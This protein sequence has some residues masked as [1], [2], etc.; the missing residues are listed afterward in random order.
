MRRPSSPNVISLQALFVALGG[1]TSLE[2]IRFWP[3]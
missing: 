1:S 3:D 2:T